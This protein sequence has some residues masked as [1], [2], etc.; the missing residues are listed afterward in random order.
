MASSESI[1]WE[2]CSVQFQPK[3]LCYSE[4][5]KIFFSVLLNLTKDIINF[6]TFVGICSTSAF[7]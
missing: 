1:V 3:N 7:I 2:L 6:I 5:N 4:V